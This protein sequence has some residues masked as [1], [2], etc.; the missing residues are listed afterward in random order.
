MIKKS[1][2][3]GRALQESICWLVSLIG[4]LPPFTP[5]PLTGHRDD[6]LKVTFIHRHHHH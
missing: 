6:A 5:R 2:K 1:Q 4:L 3:D